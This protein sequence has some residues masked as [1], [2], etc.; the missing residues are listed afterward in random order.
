MIFSLVKFPILSFLHIYLSIRANPEIGELIQVN[1]KLTLDENIADNG[2]I[3][4]AYYAYCK[5]LMYN[6]SQSKGKKYARYSRIIKCINM[7]FIF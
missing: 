1:G 6:L 5:R 4:E 2:G 7:M 3:K